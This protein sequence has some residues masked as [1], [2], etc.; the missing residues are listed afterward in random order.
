MEAAWSLVLHLPAIAPIPTTD[1]VPAPIRRRHLTISTASALQ[2]AV[3]FGTVVKDHGEVSGIALQ[4]EHLRALDCGDQLT[5]HLLDVMLAHLQ[6]T[7]V[8]CNQANG[9]GRSP[10]K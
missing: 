10:S 2:M 5:Y 6:M 9:S 1:L 8:R 4:L 7:R 3:A